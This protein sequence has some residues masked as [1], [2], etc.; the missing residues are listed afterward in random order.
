[1]SEKKSIDAAAAFAFISEK[2]PIFRHASRECFVRNAGNVIEE[3]IYSP[4]ETIASPADIAE[5]P[6]IGTVLSGNAAV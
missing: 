3:I 5:E 1:M 4:G 2:N 6:C